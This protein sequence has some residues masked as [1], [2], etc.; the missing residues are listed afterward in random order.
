MA[1]EILGESAYETYLKEYEHLMLR[2]SG[3]VNNKYFFGMTVEG[4]VS[5]AYKE[6]TGNYMETSPIRILSRPESKKLGFHKSWDALKANEAFIVNEEFDPVKLTKVP[7]VNRDGMIDIADYTA[8][9]DIVLGKD[10]VAP[11]RYDHDAA[12][13]DGDGVIDTADATALVSDYLL[14][15]NSGE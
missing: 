9:I 13:V 2:N 15:N 12:D 3:T 10:D 11:Y 4:D 5:D 7:D 14:K 6:K 1:K 8:L